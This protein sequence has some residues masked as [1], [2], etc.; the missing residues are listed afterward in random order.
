ML[1]FWSFFD[2][3]KKHHKLG[4]FFPLFREMTK[5]RSE[6]DQK[7]IKNLFKMVKSLVCAKKWSQKPLVSKKFN[8]KKHEIWRFFDVKKAGV[9]VNPKFVKIRAKKCKLKIIE[10]WPFLDFL[11][12]KNALFFVHFFIFHYYR[13]AMYVFYVHKKVMKKTKNMFAVW[14]RAEIWNF[15]FFT[16]FSGFSKKAGIFGNRLFSSFWPKITENRQTYGPF[17]KCR[18]QAKV[19]KSQFFSILTKI[20]KKW[21]KFWNRF[22]N[23]FVNFGKSR[24]GFG[25][26]P[27][28]GHDRWQISTGFAGSEIFWKN[29]EILVKKWH[30]LVK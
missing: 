17:G 18:K 21:R 5:T 26:R 4:I 27:E 25:R 1:I 28:K 13:R 3:S 11:I 19:Q 23:G 9:S 2:F 12:E 14:Q 15:W 7:C 8:L 6:N 29:H 24:I 10:K 22:W 16:V 20:V 30:T